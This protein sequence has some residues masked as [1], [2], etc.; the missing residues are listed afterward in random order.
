MSTF[1]SQVP[2]LT[3]F[4]AYYRQTLGAAPGQ[5]GGKNFI[6]RFITKGPSFRC[7]VK[8]FTYSESGSAV[9]IKTHPHV[10][11][12]SEESAKRAATTLHQIGPSPEQHW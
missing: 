3:L 11:A 12:D 5:K 2:D 1:P 10:F 6:L 8:F 4:N 9:Y 7:K